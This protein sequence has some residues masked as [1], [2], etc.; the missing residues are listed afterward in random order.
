MWGQGG[1]CSLLKTGL[2]ASALVAWLCLPRPRPPRPLRSPLHAHLRWCEIRF[3]LQVW[4]VWGLGAQGPE[5][6]TEHAGLRVDGPPPEDGA[7]SRPRSG[8]LWLLR[9]HRGT[10]A[11]W[12]KTKEDEGRSPFT[13]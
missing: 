7:Q 12:L 13:P 10:V 5:P 8:Q 2:T 9:G 3:Y 1:I 11:R 4:A 6:S